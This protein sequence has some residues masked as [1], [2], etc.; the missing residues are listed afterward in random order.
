MTNI[1]ET[2]SL[3]KN[4]GKTCGISSVSLNVGEGDI[5]GFVGPNGAGKSTF[6]KLILNLIK[7]TSGTATVF[8][9]D[10][11]KKSHVIKRSL[12]YAPSDVRFFPNMTTDQILKNTLR[13]HRNKN[14]SRIDM[15]CNR[16]DLDK[17]KKFKE[18]SLGNRKKVALATALIHEPKIIILDEPTSGLDPLIQIRLFEMLEEA[19]K[20][21]ATVFLSSHNLAEIRDHCT[22]TGFIKNGKIINEQRLD[23]AITNKKIVTITAE[24]LNR[25]IL[26]RLNVTIISDND[27]SVKFSYTGE[28]STLIKTVSCIEMSDI[29]I[30]NNSLEGEYIKYYDD[31]DKL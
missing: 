7:P 16:L 2:Q 26:E 8:E 20:K 17:N 22:V 23:T 1:I 27:N 6:I 25:E 29:I 19:A 15:I 10:V 5:F 18:L 12:G 28:L 14:Y 30:E 21:G 31:G 9:K 24:N 13:F 11:F 3:S 4:Y